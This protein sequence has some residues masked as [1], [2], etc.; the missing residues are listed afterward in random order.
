MKLFFVE[1]LPAS[2]LSL[3]LM[4]KIHLLGPMFLNSLNLCSSL[5]VRG[6]SFTSRQTTDKIILTVYFNF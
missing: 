3:S 2:L 1:L 6:P 5:I 4:I